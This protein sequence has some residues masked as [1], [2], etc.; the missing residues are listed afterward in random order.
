[1]MGGGAKTK[2]DVENGDVT[3]KQVTIETPAR[4][5]PEPSKTGSHFSIGGAPGHRLQA[6][7]DRALGKGESNGG[8][9]KTRLLTEGEKKKTSEKD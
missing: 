3:P 9:K 5:N 7:S 8:K 2:E 6:R 4:R 1:M